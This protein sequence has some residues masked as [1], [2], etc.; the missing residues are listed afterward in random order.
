MC[1][2]ACFWIQ[3][4]FLSYFYLFLFLNK[5]FPSSFLFTFPVPPTPP[6][7]FLPP[8]LSTDIACC[9]IIN[10]VFT[11]KWSAW[12]GGRSPLVSLSFRPRVCLPATCMLLPGSVV[13]RTV[14]WLANTDISRFTST[15]ANLLAK[16][17]FNHSSLV[18]TGLR[19]EPLLKILLLIFSLIS[20]YLILHLFFGVFFSFLIIMFLFC[21][22]L[23]KDIS[24]L[25]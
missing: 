8:L 2:F 22:F 7:I 17:L 3:F 20:S 11:C 10:K 6:S 21:F 23:P 19:G 1:L 12:S 13:G 25:P 16:P 9:D 4:S 14:Y 24:Y 15:W 18:N 5:F